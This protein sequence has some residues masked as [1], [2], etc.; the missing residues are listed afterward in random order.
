M[1]SDAIER[2]YKND[3]REKRIACVE[4]QMSLMIIALLY[5]LLLICKSNSYNSFILDLNEHL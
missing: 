3:D 5:F 4:K 1:G 2:S